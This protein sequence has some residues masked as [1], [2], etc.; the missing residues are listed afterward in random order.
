MSRAAIRYG[1]AILETAHDKGVATE[2]NNDM[3]DI[4]ASIAGSAELNDFLMSP[5][6]T[7]EAKES[8][9]LEIFS[10]SNGVT[11]SLFR[12]LLENKR[13]EILGSIASEYNRMF[14]EMNGVEKAKVT[15]A[16]AMDDALEAKVMSKILE[17]SNKK[18]VIE[19]IVDPAIIGGFILRIGDKQ[20]NASVADKLL[21]LKR[22]MSN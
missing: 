4:V 17:F 20:Y 12:L 19:N 21:N 7:S 10:A 16:I 11:K 15:T 1:K 9:L 13:F 14:E 6:T 18:V 5:T 3:S 2:V 22:E 8:A